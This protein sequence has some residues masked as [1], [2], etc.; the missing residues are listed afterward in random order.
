MCNI[1]WEDIPGL[2]IRSNQADSSQALKDAKA[3]ARAERDR[4]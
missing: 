4:A 2:R 3:F 1:Y